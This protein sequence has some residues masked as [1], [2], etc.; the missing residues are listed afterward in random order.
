MTRDDTMDS[1]L[2]QELEETFAR[3]GSAQAIDRLCQVLRQ[4]KDY[5]AL[6]YALL[7]KKRHELGVSPIPTGP[8]QDLPESA[9]EPYEN[10]IRD[11]GRLVGQLY[12]EEG[13]IPQAWAYF[14]ML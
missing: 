14:R 1:A 6:F 7:L 10:A 13:N 12:L 3:Q 2:F 9:H 5:S 4:K 11:A 8:A